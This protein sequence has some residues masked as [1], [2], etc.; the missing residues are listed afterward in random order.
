MT[1]DR[2]TDQSRK[3]VTMTKRLVLVALVV[4][5]ALVLAAPAM[6]FDGY[7]VD[8]TPTYGGTGTCQG[9]HGSR[10]VFS[11]W[12]TTAHAMVGTAEL[13]PVTGELAGGTA[14]AEPIADGPGCAGCHSSNYNPKLHVP[15][16][17]GVYPWQNTAGDDAFTEPFVGC[18]SCH[19]GFNSTHEAFG[20]S[21]AA[22]LANADV[23]GQCHSRYS[24]NVT[25]YENYD[26]TFSTNRQYTLGDFSPLGT[27]A[28]SWTP[29]PIKDFLKI[30]TPAV[31]QQMYYYKDADGNLLPWSARGHEEGAQQYNEWAMEGHANALT[32]IKGFGSDSCLECH[33]ADYRLAPEGEK[34]TIKEAKYGITC[35]VCHDPHEPSEQT[36]LWNEE[37]NPQLT[38]PREELCVECHNAEIPAGATATPGSDV[39]HPMK[40]MMNGTG[41]IDVPQGSPSVHK[42]KCVQCHM[43]PTDYDRN[44]VPMTGANHVFAIVEPD[45]AAEALSTGNIGGVKKPMPVSSCSSCH[46]KAGDPYARYL[47]GT[48]E[49]R[50]AQMHAWDDQ[51]GTEL[52]AAAARLGYGSTAAARTAIN[53]KAQTDW[54][55]SETAFMKAYTNRSFI[56]SEGSWGIHNWDYAR[57]V[58]LKAQEQARSVKSAVTSVTITSPLVTA[59]YGTATV[60]FGESTTVSGK[61]VLPTGADPATLL[62]GQVRLWFKPTGGGASQPIQQTFLSGTVFD[63]YMFTVMPTR[64]GTYTAQFLGND[65]WSGKVSMEY[66]GLDVAYRVTLSRPKTT[67]KLNAY[68][69]FTGTVGPI[70]F[71]EGVPVQ[72]QRKKGSGAWKNWGDPLKVKANGTFSASKKM[73]A[74]GTYYFRA[75]FDADADHV[76]GTSNRVK[77]VV[78]M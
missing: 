31:P 2:V 60:K 58:I 4:A 29:Q 15:D 26:G 11:G 65:V 3:E 24:N 38:A 30:P 71:G 77:V 54:D 67:V 23:C 10:A 21:P 59:P 73:K 48:F 5:A 27:V 17:N 42:D 12:Q 9:C 50:Q 53:K 37:R 52:T 7:R 75:V 63:E 8:Y 16:A 78:K 74:T 28:N 1:T 43:V 35:Q 51:V 47:S 57:T 34:P 39:H 70:D 62:G 25:P 46:A 56:E 13:D 40:E 72:L 41:A 36:S 6:A 20:G 18:S 64:S 44:G 76:Q 69:K 49:N 68:V 14:N 66:V 61:V 55:A 19:V 22:N 33:S 32:A 45:V